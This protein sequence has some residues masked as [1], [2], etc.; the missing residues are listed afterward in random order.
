MILFKST[1]SE[2]TKR[3]YRIAKGKKVKQ[4]GLQRIRVPLWWLIA[5]IFQLV[6]DR[7]LPF[8]PP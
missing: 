6:S 3:V 4:R 2:R 8:V 1:S 5:P 7:M